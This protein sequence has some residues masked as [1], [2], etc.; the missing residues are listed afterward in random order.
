MSC[1]SLSKVNLMLCLITHASSVPLNTSLMHLPFMVSTSPFNPP[2]IHSFVYQSYAIHVYA[3]SHFI[4]SLINRAFMKS[5]SITGRSSLWLL[6][7]CAHADMYQ[8]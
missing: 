2:L 4:S 3:H 6:I 7:K 8:N 1:V 5:S